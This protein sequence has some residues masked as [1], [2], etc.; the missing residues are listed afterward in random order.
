[1]LAHPGRLENLRIKTLKGNGLAGIEVFHPTHSPEVRVELLRIADQLLE[2]F[3][4]GRI[5][6]TRRARRKWAPPPERRFIEVL[7]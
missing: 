6:G 1:M 5:I 7:L 3:H 2:L 4:R